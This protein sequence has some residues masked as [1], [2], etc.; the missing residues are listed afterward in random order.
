M[1]LL[2]INYTPLDTWREVVWDFTLTLLLFS[3]PYRSRLSLQYHI[4]KKNY[5]YH[6]TNNC[7]CQC[8]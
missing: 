7:V 2:R 5:F 6:I 4:E 8:K 1:E 3:A